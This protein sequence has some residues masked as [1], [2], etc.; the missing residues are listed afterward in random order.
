[1]TESAHRAAMN[2][3]IAPQYDPGEFV[4]TDPW[5]LPPVREPKPTWGQRLRWWLSAIFPVSP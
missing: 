3:P 5:P 1:M 4:T 2:A